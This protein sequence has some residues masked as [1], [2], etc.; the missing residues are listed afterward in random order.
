MAKRPECDYYQKVDVKV[1]VRVGDDEEFVRRITDLT[2][3][4]VRLMEMPSEYC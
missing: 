1:W 2:E 3:R 4:H